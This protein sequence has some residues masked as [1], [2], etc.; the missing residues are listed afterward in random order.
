M[1]NINS[2]N[3]NEAEKVLELAK[4]DLIASQ[5]EEIVNR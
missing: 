2:Q 4:T 5:L 3:V 1:A